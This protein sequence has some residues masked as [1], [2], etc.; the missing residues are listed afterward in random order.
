MDANSSLMHLQDGG[1]H[2][3]RGK[4][5]GRKKEREMREKYV[6]GDISGTPQPSHL[7]TIISDFANRFR[8]FLGQPIPK[9]T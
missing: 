2:K 9:T 8:V 5:F 4:R 6:K 7:M 1:R 3:H